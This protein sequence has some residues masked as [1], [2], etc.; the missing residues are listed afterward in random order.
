MTALDFIVRRDDL[1]QCKCVP[2]AEPDEIDL[3]RGEVLL[4][5][6]KFAFTSNNVT[7]AAFGDAMRYWDF[8]P[9]PEG[10]GR[11]PVWG[12]GDVIRSEHDGIGAGERVFGYLAMSTHLV[13]QPDRVTEAGF[14]DASPHRAPLP[15]AYQQYR[16]LQSDS[17]SDQDYE[18]RLALLQPL[19]MT[20]FLV[21]D[22]LADNDL[23]GAHA[24]VLSSA[25][26]KTAL[27]VAFLLTRDRPSGCEVIGLTS[28]GNVA[29]CERLDYYDRVL[30]YGEL[31]SL[32]NEA[33]SVYVDL[34]GDGRLLHAVHH[35]FRDDLKHSCVVGATHW[36]QR[37]T[38]HAL[39]GPEPQFFFAPTQLEKRRRDWGPGG[40]EKRYGE[41]RTAFLPSSQRWMKV[42]R[43]DGPD[44]VEAVY[45]EMLEGKVNPE[46]GHILSLPSDQA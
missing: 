17:G 36:E 37:E 15:A 19:F 32:S 34:A 7:Y 31:E 42:V 35:H 4:R 27:G 16:R 39:P 2:A 10:W 22:F 38:Q 9:A 46:V 14:L 13:L 45:L 29:F 25:S 11:I 41:A 12:F 44:A 20:S 5:I 18:D 26:S 28:P 43:A 1:R 33:P 23:F 24:V 8:F 40:F 3:R 21:A 30:P 6:A